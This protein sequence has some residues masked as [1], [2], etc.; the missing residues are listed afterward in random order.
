MMLRMKEGEEQEAELACQCSNGHLLVFTDGEQT[1]GRLRQG[2]KLGFVPSFCCRGH[3]VG[4]DPCQ[5]FPKP[6]LLAFLSRSPSLSDPASTLQLGDPMRCNLVPASP[7]AQISPWFPLAHQR[8]PNPL[9]WLQRKLKGAASVDCLGPIATAFPSHPGS[10]LRELR[11]S[12]NTLDF[13]ILRIVY[14][15][16]SLSPECLPPPTIH[17]E[18]FTHPLR[19]PLKS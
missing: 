3:P 7:P 17:L 13:H 16:R 11:I 1:K 14:T 6:L 12:P 9:L 15:R 2:G 10:S 19:L 18:T 5:L 8:G 4:P